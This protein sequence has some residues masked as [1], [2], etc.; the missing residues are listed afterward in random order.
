MDSVYSC[1]T[2]DL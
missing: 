1:F 2:R